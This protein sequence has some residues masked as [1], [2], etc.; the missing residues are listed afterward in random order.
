V[1]YRLREHP[2]VFVD[3]DAIARWIEDYAG[4]DLAFRKIDEI[5][6][7]IAALAVEPHRGTRREDVQP[8]LRILTVAKKAVVAFTVNDEA[9]AVM[10]YAVTY[11]GADWA[12]I[13]RRRAR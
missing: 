6:S 1:R 2:R 11:G 13:V 9:H 10:I 5:R 8:N 4:Y 7:A 12:R 3:L